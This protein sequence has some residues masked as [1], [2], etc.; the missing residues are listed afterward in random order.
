M[1]LAKKKQK[2]RFRTF[3]LYFTGEGI[4]L[5][6]TYLRWQNHLETVSQFPICSGQTSTIIRQSPG[7]EHTVLSTTCQLSNISQICSH[8]EREMFPP[9]PWSCS[10]FPVVTE[11][12][13]FFIM[14]QLI[15]IEISIWFGH[16]DGC[17]QGQLREVACITPPSV[18]WKSDS[19]MQEHSGL[20]R[21]LMLSY[22]S[23]HPGPPPTW[24]GRT[25]MTRSASAPTS[26]SP[27][28]WVRGDLD[29]Q[30]NK[31]TCSPA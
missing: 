20:V 26:A 17:W 8:T 14:L 28:C 15:L 24:R 30:T 19:K 10:K 7:T 25:G 23:A 1:L 31:T 16:D 3:P 9:S 6:P 5:I 18:T 11:R 4:F 2:N 13:Q 29:T 21:L 27:S 12:S 22:L